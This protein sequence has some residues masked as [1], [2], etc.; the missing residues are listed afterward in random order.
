MLR[1]RHISTGNSPQTVSALQPD[2]L[3][4]NHEPAMRSRSTSWGAKEKLAMCKQMKISGGSP[5]QSFTPMSQLIGGGGVPIN[6]KVERVSTANHFHFIHYDSLN[7]FSYM[8]G[9]M[10]FGS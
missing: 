3:N 5:G 6:R 10:Y 4:N 9:N 7:V 8:S 2:L 1:R